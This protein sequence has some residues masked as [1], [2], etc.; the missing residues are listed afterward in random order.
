M[1]LCGKFSFQ[2]FDD[3]NEAKAKSK[4]DTAWFWFNIPAI[5]NAGD[6][7]YEKYVFKHLLPAIGTHPE[8]DSECRFVMDGDCLP[9]GMLQIP[10]AENAPEILEEIMKNG[11]NNCYVVGVHA[12]S[13]DSQFA[14]VDKILRSEMAGYLGCIL[15][16]GHGFERFL[17]VAASMNLVYTFNISF[18]RMIE[19][20]NCT[21]LSD[22][23]LRDWGY[24]PH[25]T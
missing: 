15:C 2:D 18:L 13:S 16:R 8:L 20:F 23:E 7:L 12:I 9:D 25:K 5:S 10:G 14:E 17:E 24:F 1:H 6:G 21:F 11:F 22:D 3:D 4:N 19:E